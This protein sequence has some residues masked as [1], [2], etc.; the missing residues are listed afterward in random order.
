M[1][2]LLLLFFNHEIIN[3]KRRIFAKRNKDEEKII[4]EANE[5]KKKKGVISFVNF[6]HILVTYPDLESRGELN[7]KHTLRYTISLN[8]YIP[9]K[10]IKYHRRIE[11]F[12]RFKLQNYLSARVQ[13]FLRYKFN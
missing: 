13:I 7:Y 8:I 2:R 3:N 10:N 12:S 9:L 6:I 4:F 1:Y 5:K 11:R